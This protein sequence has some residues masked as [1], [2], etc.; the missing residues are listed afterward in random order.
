MY[1]IKGKIEVWLFMIV[2]VAASVACS[3]QSS[4]PLPD[5]DAA[6][7]ARV[8]E[9][10]ALEASIEATAE[11]MAVAMIQA[12]VEAMPTPTAIPTS[13]PITVS[14]LTEEDNLSVGGNCSEAENQASCD[15]DQGSVP[16]EPNTFQYSD[17]RFIVP[18]RAD[19]DCGY[20]SV[21]ED[22]SISGG[23]L[24]SIHVAIFKSK[25]PDPAPDPIVYLEGGPGGYALEN[26][27]LSYDALIEP[28]LSRRHFV[29]FDQRGVGYSEPNLQCPEA[30][31]L[32]YENL[33]KNLTFD[34]IRDKDVATSIACRDR[35]VSEGVNLKSY[36]SAENGADLAALREALGYDQWNLYGISYGTRLALTTMR[37][38]PIGIRSVILDSSYPLQ[39]DL[40]ETSLSNTDR[41]FSLL[42][43]DCESDPDCN[44]AFPELE[45]MFYDLVT[46]LDTSPVIVKAVNPLNWKTVDVL[47]GGDEFT[48]IL[49]LAMYSTELIP[50]LPWLIASTYEGVYDL[51]GLVLG[52]DLLMQE[53]FSHGMYLSVM[54]GDE[55]PFSNQEKIIAGYDESHRLNKYFDKKW[56]F[57]MCEAWGDVEGDT[58]EN[59]AVI[60]DIPTL[61]LAGEYDPITP[62]FWGRE[63]AENLSE[64]FFYEFPGMGHGVSVS[65][66][67]PL[68]ITLEFLDDPTLEPNSWC[69][70]TMGPPVFV[71]P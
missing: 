47:L 15:S 18:Y 2:M 36:S 52:L 65:G 70:S 21:P 17:C 71:I 54:C 66:Q 56:I 46:Q 14:D 38:H 3:S 9:T 7:E 13:T 19:V 62:P 42:F 59:L 24:I 60:S 68:D 44:T 29:I 63:V 57:E 34:E 39:A 49:F 35:L 64:S 50:S 16:T 30:K 58:V 61:V 4:E 23:P 40:F 26:I 33:E 37:D 8:E 12:T 27:S 48:H 53:Y 31:S 10:H 69:V 45:T 67:C 41:S 43:S 55:V 25:S 6:V 22:R 1:A 20:L 32:M 28:F 5:V 11:A 51:A